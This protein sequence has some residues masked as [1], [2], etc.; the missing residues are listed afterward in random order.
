MTRTGLNSWA[1]PLVCQRYVVVLKCLTPKY[2]QKSLN[3]FPPNCGP[4]FSQKING[5]SEWN[6]LVIGKDLAMCVDDVLDAQIAL[7]NFKYQFIM[8]HMN[9]LSSF[10]LRNGYSIIIAMSSRGLNDEKSG[11]SRL[12]WYWLPFCTQRSLG[13]CSVEAV[14]HIRPEIRVF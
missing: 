11:Y 5:D 3:I 10:V 12:R 1:R 14:G 6:V 4:F 13:N 7:V 2:P 9:W 8:T